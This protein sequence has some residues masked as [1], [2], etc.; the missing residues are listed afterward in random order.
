MAKIIKT[1]W[2]GKKIVIMLVTGNRVKGELIEVADE[3]L[4]IDRGGS[5]MQ[6]MS[7][8]IVAIQS[9]EAVE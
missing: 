6:I 9:A 8:A 2:F 7:H 5:E 1:G 4:V 3:Y